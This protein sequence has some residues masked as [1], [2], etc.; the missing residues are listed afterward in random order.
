MKFVRENPPFSRWQSLSLQTSG[1]HPTSGDGMIEGDS[2]TSLE[3]LTLSSVP[4]ISVFHHIVRTSTSKLKTLC[5]Y[6][7]TF[8]ERMSMYE[9][10][11]GRISTLSLPYTSK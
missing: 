4:P 8:D 11:M 7:T 6:H 2:F 5:L 3:R 1:W 10:L 9:D